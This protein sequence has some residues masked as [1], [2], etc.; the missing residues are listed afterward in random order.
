MRARSRRR[1]NPGPRL[2]SKYSNI[3]VATEPAKL[4][5]REGNQLKKL[6]RKY[7]PKAL[8]AAVDAIEQQDGHRQRRQRRGRGAPSKM[9]E[10]MHL[11]SNIDE[12]AEEYRQAG[13]PHPY[14]SAMLDVCGFEYAGQTQR[15]DV[16]KALKAIKKK[17]LLGRRENREYME[18]L[19][20]RPPNHPGVDRKYVK[21]LLKRERKR[22][23]RRPK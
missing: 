23:Q 4:L 6:V 12:W 15:P 13:D 16:G 2:G 1:A 21:Y 14:R 19:L 5:Q 7:G 11:A 17:Y 9:H 10:R 18:H 20:K 8:I 22:S 3:P